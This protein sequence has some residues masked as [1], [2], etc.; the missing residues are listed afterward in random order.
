MRERAVPR[1][2]QNTVGDSMAK[3][4]FRD[5]CNINNI[6]KKFERTGMIDHVRS[7]EGSYGDFTDAPVD[8]Q[9][10]VNIVIAADNMFSSVPAKVRAR[11][12]NDPGEFLKF[13]EDPAN[14]EECRSLGLAVPA[15]EEPSP[16]R[17]EVVNPPS[18]G[19]G[20]SST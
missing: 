2:V 8:Y 15:P 1:F 6:M 5:E 3:Q 18:E 17:V 20:N 4:S 10:A 9:T 14:I 16:V 19:D 13:V 7:V 11:F 12:N